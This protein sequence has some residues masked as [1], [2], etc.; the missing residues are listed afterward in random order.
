R[1]YAWELFLNNDSE[2]E[3]TVETAKQ[4]EKAKNYTYEG[5]L[6]TAKNEQ[7]FLDRNIFEVSNNRLN[8]ETRSIIPY[9]TTDSLLTEE[10]DDLDTSWLDDYICMVPD[11]VENNNENNTESEEI[12][13]FHTDS[14]SVRGRLLHMLNK[15]LLWFYY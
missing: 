3:M 7:L 13:D 6:Y 4:V 12:F 8:V 2:L 1:I 5:E 14:Y 15:I 10:I 11:H 9:K